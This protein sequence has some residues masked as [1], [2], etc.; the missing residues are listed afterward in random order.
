[1]LAVLPGVLAIAVYSPPLDSRGN[2]VRGIRACEQLVERFGLHLF[3]TRPSAS[4]VRRAFDG[5]VVRSKRRRPPAH[6]EAL[7]SAG[8]GL[9]V[10]EVQGSFHFGAT[11]EL[12]RAVALAAHDA[13]HLVLDV[14]RL[15]SVD[16]G[17][18]PVLEATLRLA[19]EHGVSVVVAGAHAATFATDGVDTCSSVDAALEQCEEDLLE[20]LGLLPQVDDQHLAHQELL[21]TMSPEEIAAVRG[22][23]TVEHHPAGSRIFAQ[24]QTA[25]SIYFLVAGRVSVVLDVAGRPERVTTI[26]PGSSFGEMAIIDGGTRSASVDVEVDASCRVLSLDALEGLERDLPGFTG[27]L[28]RNLAATLSQRLR[29]ANDEVRTLRA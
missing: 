4:V 9:R 8:H 3:D 17:A 7:R 18:R 12:S 19:T 14:S 27:R 24:G 22:A 5:S 2:S 21:R 25:D 15:T 28:C 16:E 20:R 11:E 6:D 23:T 26:G 1:V 10:I 13:S 29:L